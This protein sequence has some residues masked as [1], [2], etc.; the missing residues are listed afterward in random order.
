[1]EEKLKSSHENHSYSEIILNFL[2]KLE[3]TKWSDLFRFLVY[4]LITYSL[5]RFRNQVMNR[6]L[7]IITSVI[8]QNFKFLWS[9]VLLTSGKLKNYLW[10]SRQKKH[11]VSHI[12]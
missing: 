2:H 9:Q 4:Y 3:N 8:C 1:L 5:F 7:Q 12:V 10:I 6:I 11:W